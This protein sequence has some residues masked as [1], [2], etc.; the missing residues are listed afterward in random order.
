[1]ASEQE[2]AIEYR[3]QAEVRVTN[4]LAREKALAGN[5]SYLTT[6]VEA[7]EP[8]RKWSGWDPPVGVTE[9]EK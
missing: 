5:P 3:R 2:R 9:D 4:K 7:W 8:L 6:L 1:M